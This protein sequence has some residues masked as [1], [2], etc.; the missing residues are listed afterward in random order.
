[1]GSTL[2]STMVIWTVSAATLGSQ[3]FDFQSRLLPLIKSWHSVARTHTHTHTHLST[4]TH[5][6]TCIM[7][8]LTCT[9][10]FTRSHLFTLINMLTRS[11]TNPHLMYFSHLIRNLIDDPDWDG[12]SKK[13]L[14]S[15]IDSIE[16]VK[17]SKRSAPLK[18][19]TTYFTGIHTN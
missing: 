4:R 2:G 6:L 14:F 12:S 13:I 3:F 15:L 18:W 19:Q 7:H 8:L 1:M 17:D 10:L 11:P 5:L 16:L 9:H